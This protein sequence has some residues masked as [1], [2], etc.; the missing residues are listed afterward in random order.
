VEATAD[1]PA[2]ARQPWFA[3][4]GARGGLD[5]ALRVK[6]PPHELLVP[7]GAVGQADMAQRL[8]AAAFAWAYVMSSLAQAHE[9]AA[10][11]RRCSS[12]GRASVG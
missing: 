7:S 4:L 2:T 1:S 10:A 12:P 5:T 8:P 6:A 11:D 9:K 3:Q